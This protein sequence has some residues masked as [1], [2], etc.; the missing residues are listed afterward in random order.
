ME[1]LKKKC[2][3]IKVP[4]AIYDQFSTEGEV[5]KVQFKLGEKNSSKLTKLNCFLNKKFCIH[6]FEVDYDNCE[7]NFSFKLPKINSSVVPKKIDYFGRLIMH[8]LKDTEILT[9]I[10]KKKEKEIEEQN[11]LIVENPIEVMEKQRMLQR[12][13]RAE[14]SNEK[15]DKK[16]KKDRNYVKNC[17]FNLFKKGEHFTL[18]EITNAI[19]QPV[20][21]VQ[22]I[23]TEICDKHN[24]GGNKAYFELKKQYLT[25][26]AFKEDDEELS[27]L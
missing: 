14:T 17:I 19:A 2:W 26:D 24:T 9:N 8:D 21:Y 6:N 13:R 20:S 4:A 27:D 10:Q 23:L 18:K 3:L 5:G 16:I 1:E 11:K 25:G 22:E 12:K 7:A 15:G